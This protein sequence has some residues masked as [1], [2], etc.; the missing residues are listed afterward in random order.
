M[1]YFVILDI[2]QSFFSIHPKDVNEMDHMIK[3]GI[4]YKSGDPMEL[5]YTVQDAFASEEVEILKPT[6]V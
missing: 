5:G 2:A 1:G 4:S 6:T 3:Y